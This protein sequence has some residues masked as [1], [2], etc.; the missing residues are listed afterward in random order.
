MVCHQAARHG[1]L[2][3]I[4][5]AALGAHLRHGDYIARMTVDPAAPGAADGTWFARISDALDAARAVRIAR[6][7]SES[8]AC[9]IT[10]EVAAG[11]FTGSFDPGVAPEL[12]RFPLLIDVPDVTLRGAFRM[13]V[14]GQGR[15][16]GASSSGASTMLTPDRPIEFL[17][18]TEALIVVVGHPGGSHG[19]GAEIEGFSFQTPHTEGNSGG[20]GILSLR[21]DRLLV[22]GNRF[23][24]GLTSAVDLRATSARLTQNFSTGL[25]VNCGLCLAGPGDY[26]A[27]GNRVLKGGLGGIYVSAVIDHMPFSL[28]AAPAAPVEPYVLPAAASVNAALVNNDIRDHV[29]RPIGF[30]VRVLALGPASSGVQQA[31]HVVL[32]GNDMVGNTFGLILDAGFPQ[33]N[34]L[35]RGDMDVELHGNVIAASCQNNLL[36]AFTRHTGALGTTS[37]PYILNST[38]RVD[39][40]GDLPWA[41][42]WYANPAG[43]GNTLIVD[44]AVVQPGAN[45]AYDPART[46]P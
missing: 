15:A 37:N 12:E 32:H 11:T 21:A 16:T 14:D 17:P 38:Y 9:R 41:E 25:G 7:E 5:P 43:N 45:A 33:A 35:R 3:D 44:G 22:R 46:C 28:G 36:I 34:T 42:A 24:P 27:D 31:S 2:L 20:V 8:A 30:A 26:V 10:I 6:N 13:A 39:L 19:D 1:Q 23:E 18:N 40:G 4:S 29:R